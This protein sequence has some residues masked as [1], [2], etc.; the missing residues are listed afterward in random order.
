MT[1]LNFTLSPQSTQKVHEALLCLSRFSEF[2]S[3][4]ARR[5]QLCLSALNSTK[6]AYGA[7]RL[8]ANKFCDEFHFVPA[9]AGG[10]SSTG[11]SANTASDGAAGAEQ[12]FQCRL[13]ARALLA[14]FRQRYPDSR[15]KASSTAISRCEVRLSAAATQ[16]ECRLLVKLHCNHG[17]LKTHRLT[18]EDVDVMHAIFDRAMAPQHWKIAGS[19]LKE[20]MEHFGPKAEQLDVSS[21]AASGRAAFT[22]FT[23]KLIDGKEIVKQPLQTSVALDTADFDVFEVE[24]GVRVSVSLKDFK[25]ITAHASTLDVPVEAWYSRP[26]RPMQVAYARD[27]MD[28]VFTL[29]TA[30]DLHA[31][32]NSSG[33]GRIV[34]VQ[35]RTEEPPV[36]LPPPPSPPLQ[37]QPSQPMQPLQPS[38]PPPQLPLPLQEQQQQQQD[39][40]ERTALAPPPRQDQCRPTPICSNNQAAADGVDDDEEGLYH[41]PTPQPK[42]I[43]RPAAALPPMP[44]TPPPPPRTAPLFLSY[45]SDDGSDDDGRAVD[46]MQ[47]MD[48][49]RGSFMLGWDTSGG[50]GGTTN[51]IF[52]AATTTAATAA[53]AR[54]RSARRTIPDDDDDEEEEEEDTAMENQEDRMEVEMEEEEVGIGPTQQSVPPVSLI[55]ELAFLMV[56]TN[57]L[58]IAR[59]FVWLGILVSIDFTCIACVEFGFLFVLSHSFPAFFPFFTRA[60]VCICCKRIKVQELVLLYAYNLDGHR[61]S[62]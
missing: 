9:G 55:F 11:T 10:A 33:M 1:T 38:Q 24:D 57:A 16:P 49:E 15:D 13:Q 40:Q 47:A 45:D 8:S 30:A 62:V 14:V 58:P 20:Y 34:T 29:M 17:V 59:G 41:Q 22:S 50:T 43:P 6:S 42:P 37:E 25:A 2:V 32:Q 46:L 28:V 52:A 21:A 53:T 36:P 48:D 12:R 44:P 7:V 4:E 51:S 5:N 3:L 31:S 19:L 26:G 61:P 60:F 23:E 39:R 56:L 35:R 54:R 27:G 18:Y